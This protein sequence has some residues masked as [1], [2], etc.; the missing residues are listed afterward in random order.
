MGVA[1]SPAVWSVWAHRPI[2]QAHIV[3]GH[4]HGQSWDDNYSWSKTYG[5]PGYPDGSISGESFADNHM[6][7]GISWEIGW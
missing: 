1:M 3:G 6:L 5:I 4:S 2:E 7:S